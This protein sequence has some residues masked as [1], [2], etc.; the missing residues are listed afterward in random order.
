MP[1]LYMRSDAAV[2]VCAHKPS[3]GAAHSLCVPL[4]G[5][6]YHCVEKLFAHQP[7][8]SFHVDSHLAQW[9]YEILFIFSLEHSTKSHVRCWET[10]KLAWCARCTKYTA[11][12]VVFTQSRK[13][14]WKLIFIFCFSVCLACDLLTVADYQ[15]AA[16]CFL[17]SPRRSQHKVFSLSLSS[18]LHA[19]HPSAGVCVC[20]FLALP[21][22]SLV[23]ILIHHRH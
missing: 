12:L 1:F 22:R 8:A 19:S 13:S 17:L 3:L 11:F 7:S 18:T 20:A 4:S 16:R 6:L 21:A 9:R 23:T 14:Y 15:R 2:C 10:E 5:I